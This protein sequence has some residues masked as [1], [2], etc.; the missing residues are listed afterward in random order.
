MRASGGGSLTRSALWTLAVGVL[1]A[2]S[3]P[4]PEPGL[5]ADATEALSEIEDRLMEAGATT[6]GFEVSAEGA[7]SASLEGELRLRTGDDVE[8]E[9]AGTFGGVP[10]TL[11]LASEDGVMTWGNQDARREGP[12]PEALREALVI[13]LTRMGILHNL[14]RLVAGAPP[15]R[16]DGSVRSWVEAEGVRWV[17]GGPEDYGPGLSFNIRVDGQEAGDATLWVSPNGTLLR[18]DQVVRF[19]GG[20]MLVRES[21]R[22]P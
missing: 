13:G 14:A 15:D 19:P 2:C 22:L 11:A 5:P 3:G 17:E 12:H 16:A 7:F 1:A 9:A 18:R 20:E 21:Y 6:V 8:L 10:V 4:E